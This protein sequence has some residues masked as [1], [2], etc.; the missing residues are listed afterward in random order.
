MVLIKNIEIS[1]TVIVIYTVLE[2]VTLG[3]VHAMA[4]YIFI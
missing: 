3:G 4:A 2:V 1:L